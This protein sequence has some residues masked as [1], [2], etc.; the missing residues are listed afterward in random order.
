MRSAACCPAP[1]GSPCSIK[2]EA[3]RASGTTQ[4]ASERATP[5][6]LAKGETRGNVNL[7]LDRNDFAGMIAGKVTADAAAKPG[8]RVDLDRVLTFAAGGQPPVTESAIGYTLTNASGIYRFA[9]LASGGYD[10]RFSDPAHLYATVFYSEPLRL[11]YTAHGLL[12]ITGTTHFD[13]D[14]A[15]VR[16]GTIQGQ[17]RRND[18][19][20]V[21]GAD[22]RLYV[23]GPAHSWQLVSAPEVTTGDDGRYTLSGLYPGTYR[24]GFSW[25]ELD[26]SAPGFPSI[27]R[28]YGGSTLDTAHDITVGAGEQHTG[29]DVV[30]TTYRAFL[31]VIWH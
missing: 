9:G 14:V 17:L 6:V 26:R 10:L 15:L 20:P 11:V 13:V 2:T 29:I 19:R 28:F 18:G 12:L 16:A 25:L 24:V 5:I 8:I 22:V 21:A 27:E 3:V 7:A 23:L 1:T 4:T 31:P 30:Y